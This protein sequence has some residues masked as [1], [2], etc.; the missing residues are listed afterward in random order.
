MILFLKHIKV[1]GPGIFE[2]LLRQ[3]FAAVNT[4]E[5]WNN[6]NLPPLAVCD[7]IISLG[8]PMNVYETNKYSFLAKEEEFLKRAIKRNIPIL[9]ICLGA[10]L[11]AKARG[12]KVAKASLKEIGWYNVSLTEEG[13]K[14]KIF[15]DLDK[16]LHVFEWHEDTFE[17]PCKSRLLATSKSC[18]N[19]AVKFGKKAWGLQFHIEVDNKGI[20]KWCKHYKFKDYT[21][22]FLKMYFVK[23]ESYTRQAEIICRN[24]ANVIL[25]NR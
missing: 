15:K 4:V 16:N 10:Q 7:A 8:G 24:F 9:G 13:K 23:K 19:Q 17:L 2:Y 5:L 3:Y 25:E 11:L 1:E 21:D 14:D 18:H 22:D 20:K 6:E 12:A